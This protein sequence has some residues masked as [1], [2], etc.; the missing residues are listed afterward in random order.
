MVLRAQAGDEE[1]ITE[2][3]G[4]ARPLVER[5]A[6]RYV[7]DASRAEDLA[8]VALMKAFTR[9][10][11]VRNPAA[12][13]GWLL[14]ITRN[15][16][17]NELARARIAQ[18]PMS[19]MDREGTEIEAP[20]GGDG[21]PEE[22]L[23]RG[24]LQELVRRVVTTLPPHYRAT[25]TMRALEDRSYEEISDE[26]NVP[27]TVA[28]LWYCRARKRFR[29]AFVDAVVER[30]GIDP[31]C[32]GMAA[33]IAELIEGTLRRPD[34]DRLQGHLA[35]CHVCR[36]TE[37]EL[38]NTAFRAPSA[39]LLIGLGLVH[40]P[41]RC[42]RQ[43][44][45]GSGRGLGGVAHVA[46]ATVLTAA[47]AATLASGAGIGLCGPVAAPVMVAA[48]APL[49]GAGNGSA[50]GAGWRPGGTGAFGGWVLDLSG[51]SFVLRSDSLA[52]DL[53]ATLGGLRLSEIGLLGLGARV[54]GA[55]RPV[56]RGLASAPLP[57]LGLDL[58]GVVGQVSSPAS[59][60]RTGAGASSPSSRIV[61]ATRSG[62]PSPLPLAVPG[63]VSG[64]GT[65]GTP[66]LP[67]GR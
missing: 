58:I 57:G 48:A 34:R 55:L 6:A 26:L 47:G 54:D 38:R 56:E 2:L 41:G 61:A 4:R 1:A 40:L 20:A 8:Q 23:V 37:E 52:G 7:S 12:F 53:L 18:V 21:D 63:V 39:A 10:G 3:A 51:G 62:L 25:L 60:A 27:V 14:R 67:L 22:V 64:T 42:L 35:G 16:C 28:R 30:R 33:D 13:C 17:I 45:R 50:T 5:Y 44:V 24:Q 46:R 15:E 32:R 19:T 65:G 66:P 36:Q 59:G 9:V 29:T 43:L 11:D 49:S 31:V